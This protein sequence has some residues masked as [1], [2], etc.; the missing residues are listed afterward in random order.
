MVEVAATVVVAGLVVGAA[1][2]EKFQKLINMIYKI[3]LFSRNIY[4]NLFD[5]YD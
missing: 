5:L 1:T 4:A 2:K 3:L